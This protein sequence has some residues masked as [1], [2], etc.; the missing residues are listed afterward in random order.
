[1][2]PSYHKKTHFK[3]ATTL[4]LQCEPSLRSNVAKLR[5]DLHLRNFKPDMHNHHSSSMLSEGSERQAYV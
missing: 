3:A 4:Q 5:E 1:M 2:I